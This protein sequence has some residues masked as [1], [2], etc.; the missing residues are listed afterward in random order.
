[1]KNLVVLLAMAFAFTA[2]A[3]GVANIPVQLLEIDNLG[4]A[5]F[6]ANALQVNGFTNEQVKYRNL[7]SI[8]V[9]GD[10]KGADY[11]GGY[12]IFTVELIPSANGGAFQG[13]ECHQFMSVGSFKISHPHLTRPVECQ[14]LFGVHQR[15]H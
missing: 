6:L 14:K 3:G 10:E 15:F 13:I 11:K 5:E 9:G 8:V 4:R 12:F 7:R 2:H 1:M